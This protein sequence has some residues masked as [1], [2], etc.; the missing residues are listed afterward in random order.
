MSQFFAVFKNTWHHYDRFYAHECG[1]HCIVSFKTLRKM[2]Y[3][4]AC[5]VINGCLALI[6]RVAQISFLKFACACPPLCRLFQES[7]TKV[8]YCSTVIS[9]TPFHVRFRA[10]PIKFV[11]YVF[12]TRNISI[13]TDF[14]LPHFHMIS[15]CTKLTESRFVVG[16]P[17]YRN[18][19]C[20]V[21]Q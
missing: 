11:N 2:T 18:H 19:R 7:C 9:G 14:T 12:C 6:A 8:Q 5:A 20:F 17:M 1:M 13:D 10:S 3:I 21:K 15:F 16:N 4:L